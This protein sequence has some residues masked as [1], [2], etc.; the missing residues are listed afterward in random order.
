LKSLPR[1][2]YIHS[3]D[4]G[5]VLVEIFEAFG[6]VN[7]VLAGKRFTLEKDSAFEL[8]DALLMIAHDA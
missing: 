8:A 6:Y 2:F 1:E 7:I 5:S 4:G 3:P